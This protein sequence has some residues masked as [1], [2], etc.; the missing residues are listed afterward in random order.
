MLTQVFADANLDQSLVVEIVVRAPCLNRQCALPLLA[1]PT[2]AW[3]PAHQPAAATPPSSLRRLHTQLTLQ[4]H[5]GVVDA[6]AGAYF[7]QDQAQHNDAA[8]AQI[9]EARLDFRCWFHAA[10]FMLPAAAGPGL[11]TCN[12]LALGRPTT[13]ELPAGASSPATLVT[14]QMSSCCSALLLCPPLPTLCRCTCWDQQT[15]RAFHTS[16]TSV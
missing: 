8:H 1:L 11:P 3:L 2:H 12:R 14:L 10:G 4:E 5:Q 7:F 9:D 16:C 15:H 13:A 6:D